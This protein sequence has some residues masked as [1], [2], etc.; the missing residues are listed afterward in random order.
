MKKQRK[1]TNIKLEKLE[2]IGEIFGNLPSDGPPRI[3]TI[4]K[5]FFTVLKI[6]LQE[7]RTNTSKFR[8]YFIQRLKILNRLI[9]IYLSGNNFT[10]IGTTFSCDQDQACFI[11]RRFG[12][13][14]QINS[15]EAGVIELGE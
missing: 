14:W 10:G 1:I 9:K 2:D 13:V 8:T 7:P 5:S 6:L 15:H 3:L 4:G 11:I 12:W